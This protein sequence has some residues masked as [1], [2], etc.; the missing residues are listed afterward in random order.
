MADLAKGRLVTAH[1]S[2]VDR[3]GRHVCQVVV[4]G[5]DVGL[6][7]IRR[8]FAWFFTRYADELPPE[9]RSSYEKA[10]AQAKATKG[11]LWRDEAPVA[12]WAFREAKRNAATTT[13]LRAAP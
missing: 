1:C 11:G 10:E 5:V 6:E 3:Y 8:G 12:P 7:Q 2:K 9:R 13:P 4:N